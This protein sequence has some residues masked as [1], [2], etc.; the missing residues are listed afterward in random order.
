M[1][2]YIYST[3]SQDTAYTSYKPLLNDRDISQVESKVLIKGGSGVINKNLVT[4]MGTVTKVT[5]EEYALLEENQV[6]QMH[7][8]NGFIVAERAKA[9]INKVA[10]DMES[11]DRGSQLIPSDLK[12]EG[13]PKVLENRI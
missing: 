12:K 7:V 2:V 8:Q 10:K 3:L 13:M 1:S 6:F 9:S 4:P 5:D 11:R